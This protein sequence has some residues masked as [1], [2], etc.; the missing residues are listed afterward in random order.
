MESASARR[1][2]G[3][4]AAE[5]L[6]VL[7]DARQPL[8]PQEVR[9]RLGDD[10]LSYS[11]VVTILSRLH[12]KN[13]LIRRARG[14]AFA[15]TPVT[16]GPGLV[17]RRMHQILEGVPDREAVLTRFVDDLST[18]DEELLRRLLDAGPSSGR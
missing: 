17:A 12:A 2:S 1:A 3:T 8:T 14:R 16:D 5:V 18:G 6:A 13:V 15:Y 9:E 7:Q 11:T 10:R 4:L